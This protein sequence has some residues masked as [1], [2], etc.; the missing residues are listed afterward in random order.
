[1]LSILFILTYF[2]IILLSYTSDAFYFVKKVYFYSHWKEK[3]EK[4]G[5]RSFCI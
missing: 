2:Q 5:S 3:V 4:M 1:M